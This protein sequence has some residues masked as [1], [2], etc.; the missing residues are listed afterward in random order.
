MNYETILNII[1]E[2]GTIAGTLSTITSLI[3]NIKTLKGKKK[4]KK[5]AEVVKKEQQKKREKR[6]HPAKN[7][8]R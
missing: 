1:K 4:K 7:K 6:R 8:R 3:I 2:V 5:R